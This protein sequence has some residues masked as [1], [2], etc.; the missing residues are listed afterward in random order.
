MKTVELKQVF[1]EPVEYTVGE[2]KA[3]VDRQ[4]LYVEV[5]KF[6]AT[7]GSGEELNS[8]L[9]DLIKNNAT[10]DV[11]IFDDY[12]GSVLDMYIK[13]T[14]NDGIKLYEQAGLVTIPDTE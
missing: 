13:Q 10:G 2:K 11:E 9:L 4:A 6:I 1:L 5:K 12:P 14:I 8:T 7:Y 3:V